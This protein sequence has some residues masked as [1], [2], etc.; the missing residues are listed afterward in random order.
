M[1][2]EQDMDHETLSALVPMAVVGAETS[3]SYPAPLPA[4]F[5]SPELQPEAEHPLRGLINLL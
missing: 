5:L 2:V 3:G 4:S 1:L